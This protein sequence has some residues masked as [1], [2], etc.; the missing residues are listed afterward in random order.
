MTKYFSISSIVRKSVFV[1]ND[2]M[3]SKTSVKK[4][5]IRESVDVLQLEEI[6]QPSWAGRVRSGTR[7]NSQITIHDEFC[8]EDPPFQ[9]N[10]IGN[11]FT[12]NT[13]ELFTVMHFWTE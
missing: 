11:V 7:M 8:T 3:S 1:A 5:V 12:V 10:R 2:V 13:C 9:L 4:Q 6:V